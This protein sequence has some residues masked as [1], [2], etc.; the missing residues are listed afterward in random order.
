MTNGAGVYSLEFLN[1]AAPY[2]Y[3]IGADCALLRPS[4]MI[5]V[6][7]WV[8]PEA[9]ASVKIVQKGDWDG[10]GLGLDKYK[11]FTAGV[12][13]SEGK[14]LTVYAN[15]VPSLNRWYHLAMTYD[16]SHLV[17]YVNG[18][19]VGERQVSGVMTYNLAR[20]FSFGS[21]NGAQKYFTGQVSHV[22]V[23]DSAL[24]ANEVASEYAMMSSAY[25]RAFDPV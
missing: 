7:A 3:A 16:G 5:T 6:E 23:F 18:V 24:T 19:A 14:A 15:T 12:S 2:G 9:V 25:S 1:G 21:D 8:Y 20:S 11:G 4:T 10:Y 13:T 17:L 22:C